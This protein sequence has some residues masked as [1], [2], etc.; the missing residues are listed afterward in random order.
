[1]IVK[2]KR[3]AGF[4]LIELIVVMT[5]IGIVST[6]ALP[7]FLAWT[8]S[9]KYKEAARNLA[10]DMRKARAQAVANNREFR[11]LVDVNGDGVVTSV[12]SGGNVDLS[13][14]PSGYLIEQGSLASN[15][16][17]YGNWRTLEGYENGRPLISGQGP[18]TKLVLKRGADC[19]ILTDPP[20]HLQ[21]NPSGTSGPTGYYVC[22]MDSDRPNQ[23]RWIIGVPITT[24]ARVNITR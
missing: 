3:E 22:I 23:R 1:M 13:V 9:L 18:A 15:T 8:R 11:V 16:T 5:V 10:S 12:R 21:F 14:P 4:T 19:N 20:S 24:S 6:I 17:A 7:D 2:T